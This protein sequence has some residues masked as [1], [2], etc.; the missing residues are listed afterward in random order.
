MCLSHGPISYPPPLQN[1][2]GAVSYGRTY[3]AVSAPVLNDALATTVQSLVRRA[4]GTAGRSL[5]ALA[6]VAGLAL[7]FDA[8]PVPTGIVTAASTGG[9]LARPPPLGAASIIA[10]TVVA[11]RSNRVAMMLAIQTAVAGASGDIPTLLAAADALEANT[12]VPA[13]LTDDAL[14]VALQTLQ[15]VAS[16]AADDNVN[17]YLVRTLSSLSLAASG[18]RVDAVASLVDV[19]ASQPRRDLPFPGMFAS[20][21]APLLELQI[22]NASLLAYDSLLLTRNLS[23]SDGARVVFPLPAQLVSSLSGALGGSPW[24]TVAFSSFGFDVHAAQRSSASPTPASVLRLDFSNGSAAKDRPLQDVDGAFFFD[25]PVRASATDTAQAVCL[26]WDDS[27]SAWDTEACAALP[28]P[29][30]RDHTVFW[31]ASRTASVKDPRYL[32]KAWSIAGPLYNATDCQEAVIDCA[33]ELSTAAL[34]RRPVVIVANDPMDPFNTPSYR[35]PAGSTAVLR[36]FFGERCR[37]WKT[38]PAENPYNCSWDHARQMFLGSGCV[39]DAKARCACY[40]RRLSR[41]VRSRPQHPV[42]SQP[43]P[44]PSFLRSCCVAS[45]FPVDGARVAAAA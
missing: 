17:G 43:P 2:C 44:A 4:A 33:A 20:Y 39:S 30:P 37:L 34:N 32:I 8:A 14:N 18:S 22:W 10:A 38:A 6:H 42:Q 1:S 23:T 3:V 36:F 12:A 26:A 19:I 40:Q 27:G 31:D 28:N 24:T 5:Q 11:R 45:S 25:V 13:E 16:A 29:R 7:L 41:D 9:A 21:Q 35:C 15:A